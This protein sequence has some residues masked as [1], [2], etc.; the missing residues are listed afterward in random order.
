GRR[1]WHA[2]LAVDGPGQRVRADQTRPSHARLST[3]PPR[4]PD[5]SVGALSIGRG[6]S[7]PNREPPSYLFPAWRLFDRVPRG[8]PRAGTGRC[9]T[10]ARSEVRRDGVGTA[11]PRA[12]AGGTRG[13]T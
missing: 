11:W 4:H 8:D 6:R 9:A 2:R 1:L 12:P 3:T 10:R 13:R 5:R 7:P